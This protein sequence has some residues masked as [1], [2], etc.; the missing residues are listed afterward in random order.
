[1][2]IL[3]NS[4]VPRSSEGKSKTTAE[5]AGP[6]EWT[7]R[8]LR[9]WEKGVARLSVSPQPPPHTSAMPRC[10]LRPLGRCAEAVG[11]H[12]GERGRMMHTHTHTHTHTHSE[13]EGLGAVICFGGR[14][15]PQERADALGVGRFRQSPMGAPLPGTLCDARGPRTP[16]RLLEWLLPAPPAGRRAATHLRPQQGASQSSTLREKGQ[17]R[18]GGS[19]RSSRGADPERSSA[20]LRAGRGKRPGSAGL[21]HHRGH[22]ELSM[23]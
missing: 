21:T 16:C 17:G 8:R 15:C 5:V 20:V 3:P 6:H 19:G 23:G 10:S 2:R 4:G 13:R 9:G 1:L 7:T 14:G 18:E 11:A 22:R 12:S